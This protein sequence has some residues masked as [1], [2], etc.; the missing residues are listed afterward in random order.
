MNAIQQILIID[1]DPFFRS[2]VEQALWTPHREV[3]SRSNG[4]QG[5]ASLGRDPPDLV[6]LDLSL[7]DIA[8]LDVLQHLRSGEGWDS[9][10]IVMLTASDQLDDMLEA[11][12]LGAT[13]YLNK[14]IEPHALIAAVDDLLGAANLSWIDDVTRAYRTR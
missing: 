2:L 8:G 6:L 5:I 9:V 1:D 7:P 4:A 14:P 10:P 13:G 3:S 12:R 11:K